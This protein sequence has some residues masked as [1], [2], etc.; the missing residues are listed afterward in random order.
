VIPASRRFLL[1]A[2]VR[3]TAFTAALALGL[4]ACSTGPSAAATV[5]DRE[6]TQEELDASIPLYE[7]LAGLSQGQCGTQAADETPAQACARFTLTN[8]IQEEV[9][10]DYAGENDVAV[11]DGDAQRTIDD[12]E[13]QVGAKELDGLLEESDVTR[14]EL[15]AFAGRLLLFQRVQQ[16]VSEEEVTDEELQAEYDRRVSDFTTLHAQHILLASEKDAREI[17][18][19]VTEE[20]FEELAR[21]SSIDPS[22]KENGGDLGTTPATS[23]DQTFVRAALALEPGQISQPIETQFGWHVIRLVDEP[24]VVAFEEVREQLLAQVAGTTFQEWLDGA[25]READ[26]EANPRYGTFDLETGTVEPVR[27]TVLQPAQPSPLLGGDQ[28]VGGS[29]SEAGAGPAVPP[30]S[31][32]PAQTP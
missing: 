16:A 24:K 11:P 15:V 29:G 8:L 4:T 22:A 19:Q 20:N 28:G 31:E 10:K 21:E 2:F 32:A 6:I 27:S 26:V 1:R 9:V 13:G 7:F 17:A 14:D 18:D 25:Y 30:P 3:L 12:L 5:G 23:L